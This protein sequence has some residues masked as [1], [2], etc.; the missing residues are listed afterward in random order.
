MKLHLSQLKQVELA[1][2]GRGMI[3][4]GQVMQGVRSMW[5][6]GAT[7]KKWVGRRGKG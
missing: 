3:R 1:G 4:G 2:G 7:G 5:A 6:G